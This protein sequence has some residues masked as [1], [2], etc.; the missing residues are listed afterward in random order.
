MVIGFWALLVLLMTTAQANGQVSIGSLRSSIESSNLEV[1]T[2][3][4]VVHLKRQNQQQLGGR[5]GGTAFVLTDD[6]GSIEVAIRRVNRL[7]MPL[8]EGDRVEVTAQIEVFRNRDNVPLR[9][10]VEA[11]EIQHLG[12]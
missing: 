8:R 5:C 11:T 10:C 4:G 12:P 7:I 3:H 1:V 2:L 6:T 9:I